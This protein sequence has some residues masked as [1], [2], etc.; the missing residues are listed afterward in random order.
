M[1]DH[2]FGIS[3]ALTLQRR[4]VELSAQYPYQEAVPVSPITVTP[5]ADLGTPVA[6]T[7]RFALRLH[8]APALHSTTLRVI[9]ASAALT[10][11]S[12]PLT[13]ADG[14]TWAFCGYG[15]NSGYA[16]M[17]AGSGHAP[18]TDPAMLLPTTPAFRLH[19]P[20]AQYVIVSHFNAP[21]PGYATQYPG[22]LAKHEGADFEPPPGSVCD[23]VVHV[24]AAGKVVKVDNQPAGYGSYLV[25][26]HADG[27][28]TVYA[29]FAEI[30]VK[31]GQ[32]LAE[33]QI[34]GLM[35][36][37]GSSSEPHVHV[38]VSNPAYGLPNYVYPAVVDP[39]SVLV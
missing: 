3:H 23:P 1:S 35:G 30:Y 10:V 21:R 37:T 14:F 6:S 24:G 34:I 22:K 38:T 17:D 11:Y 36:C 8:T 12:A 5:P 20:F 4:L 19:P 15:A 32:T 7:T 2:G 29:H 28:Q 25:I 27:W 13:A 33:G 9:P 16:A 39:E 18:S 26:D 31:A